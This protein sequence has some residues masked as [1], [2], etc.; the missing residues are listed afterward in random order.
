M[1]KAEELLNIANTTNLAE[2]Y[3][4][5][6]NH[7]IIEDNYD[8]AAETFK[9]AGNV[10]LNNNNKYLAAGSFVK[11]SDNY[12]KYKDGKFASAAKQLQNLG[13]IYYQNKHIEL[14]IVTY[15]KSCKYFCV[16]KSQSTGYGI[17][18]KAAQLAIDNKDYTKAISLLTQVNEYYESNKLTEFKCKQLFLEISILKLYINDDC[19]SY[20]VVEGKHRQTREYKLIDLLIKSLV[21][22]NKEQFGVAI[23]D[24]DSIQ[25]LEG[26]KLDLLTEIQQRY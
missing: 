11:A 9:E 2:D 21:E 23:S 6:G 26:W 3:V 12:I 13:D 10:Y 24:F 14:A 5:A 22:K 1:S 17:L 19:M 25:P 7:F 4:K 8:L 16:E 20:F 18:Y 15:E